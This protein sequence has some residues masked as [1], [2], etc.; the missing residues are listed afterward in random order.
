M[1]S[2][3]DPDPAAFN[4]GEW[5]GATYTEDGK[6]IYAVVHN[7]YQGGEHPGQCSLDTGCWYNSL[8][9]AVS[10]DSGESYQHPVMP[11]GH[12]VASYPL[13]YGPDIGI[14]GIFHPSNI[15]KGKDGFY[16]SIVQLVKPLGE[17]VTGWV[18]LMRTHDLSDPKSWRYWDGAGFEGRFINP[19]IEPTDNPDA[20]E[21]TPLEGNGGLTNSLTYNN[22][23]D[24][25]VLL[26]PGGED[27]SSGFY[28]A[29]SE[30]LIHWT[31]F[32]LLY[33]V[34]PFDPSN[35]TDILYQYPSLLDPNSESR[36]FE[37]TGKTAY[38][39]Y[40]RHNISEGGLDRDLVRIPV[41]FFKE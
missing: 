30:D 2:D 3:R 39:Y 21:C 41:E 37:T 19:Y 27:E 8:T 10:T 17:G 34:L 4:D 14:L 25:Y 38:L 23:I 28:Y 20:H 16:Y 15:V 11:P 9:L 24:R 7:E 6:T 35:T 31:P 36:N 1:E 33:H 26:G 22:Y 13:Q 5:I 12:L 40:T 32:E 29:L 18:C